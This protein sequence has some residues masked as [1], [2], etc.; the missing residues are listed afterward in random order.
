MGEP[1]GGPVVYT[2]PMHPDVVSDQP[3]RCPQCGMKMLATAAP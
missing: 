2:C 1:D 3:G